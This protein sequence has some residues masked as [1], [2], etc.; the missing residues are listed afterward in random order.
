M[1]NADVTDKIYIFI[2]IYSV[3]VI[4]SFCFVCLIILIDN[5]EDN[6]NLLFIFIYRSGKCH[7]TRLFITFLGLLA[8]FRTKGKIFTRAHNFYK[9]L[10]YIG[11]AKTLLNSPG[12]GF[13]RKCV[14]ALN[15]WW[16]EE[17]RGFWNKM[18]EIKV[19]EERASRILMS[20]SA[21]SIFLQR[22]VVQWLTCLFAFHH[23]E[24]QE[25]SLICAS[26]AAI[27]IVYVLK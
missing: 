5:D 7:L 19:D 18:R 10:T 6:W 24:S 8:I 23:L 27:T 22:C 12:K 16:A 1:S 26:C 3:L 13:L 11:C 20:S 4:K 21:V 14:W 15:N 17:N 25:R 9:H 2:A